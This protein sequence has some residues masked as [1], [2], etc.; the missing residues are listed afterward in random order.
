M[1]TNNSI[2]QW[3]K[4]ALWTEIEE[5]LDQ[6]ERSKNRIFLWTVLIGIVLL[7][8]YFIQDEYNDNSTVNTSI[9]KDESVEVVSE[10]D[11]IKDVNTAPIMMN[12]SMDDHSSIVKKEIIVRKEA[13]AMKQNYALGQRSEE[14]QQ[15]VQPKK[16]LKHDSILL[17]RSIVDAK[18]EE[19][20]GK[21]IKEESNIRVIS[22]SY[23]LMSLVPNELTIQHRNFEQKRMFNIHNINNKYGISAEYSFG[24]S[25]RQLA[26]D[27][28]EYV[29]A[30][31]KY[32]RPL[33]SQLFSIGINRNIKNFTVQLG[34]SYERSTVALDYSDHRQVGERS[35]YS[36]SAYY[37]IVSGSKIYI[38]G[39][40]K[41]KEYELRHIYSPNRIE[42]I[43]IP[44]QIGYSFKKHGVHLF[45]SY[46]HNVWQR[47]QGYFL[48]EELALIEKSD[49]ASINEMYNRKV[50][51]MAIEA[52]Y[53][54]IRYRNQSLGL[55]TKY[56]LDLESH[57]TTLTEKY[58]TLF[59]GFNWKYSF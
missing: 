19:H 45:A 51:R 33:E 4:E 59:L 54:I 22:P 14:N 29:V 43:Y 48:D 1:K 41:V 8:T 11:H 39:E 6:K 5:S 10:N 2:P 7:A 15:Y 28:I 31:E 47:H 34:F 53:D 44:I 42:R 58:T 13:G 37:Q 57:H 9:S 49:R 16:S 21:K 55:N 23:L 26:G 56:M 36:D 25:R 35:V 18:N 30:K 52:S 20:I 27:N 40:R 38:P 24:F 46:Y 3:D 12:N 50:N 17:Y 32:E